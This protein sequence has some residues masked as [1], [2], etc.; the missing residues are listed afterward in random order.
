MKTKKIMFNLFVD[1]QTLAK[2]DDISAKSHFV[3][4]NFDAPK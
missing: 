2:N 1:Y 3:N 4:L